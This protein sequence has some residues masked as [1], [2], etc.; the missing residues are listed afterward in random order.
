[1]GWACDSA[2]RQAGGGAGC[3]DQAG[4]RCGESFPLQASFSS[5][6]GSSFPDPLLAPLPHS[7]Q[8]SQGRTG[9]KGC[10]PCMP[11]GPIA[12]AGSPVSQQKG[13]AAGQGEQGGD[14]SVGIN[15]H[16]AP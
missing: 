4:V 15:P 2:P 16:A 7:K 14:A 12:Q 5:M 6:Y 13:G 3:W 11:C 8:V 9:G 10:H 1:M